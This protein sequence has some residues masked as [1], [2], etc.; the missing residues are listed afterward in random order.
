MFLLCG[1]NSKA[2]GIIY[3]L[4]CP[5]SHYRGMINV[6]ADIDVEYPIRHWRFNKKQRSFLSW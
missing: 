1:W 4:T 2:P 5:G 6:V 3:T